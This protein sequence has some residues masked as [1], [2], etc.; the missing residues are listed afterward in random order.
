[1]LLMEVNKERLLEVGSWTCASLH[2]Y[3]LYVCMS[4]ICFNYTLLSFVLPLFFLE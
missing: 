2:I 3:L 4:C 1:M